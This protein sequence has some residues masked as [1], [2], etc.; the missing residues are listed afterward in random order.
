MKKLDKPMMSVKEIMKDISETVLDTEKKNN[1]IDAIDHIEEC[2]IEYD[3][4]AINHNLH[5]IQPTQNTDTTLDAT[6]MQKLYTEKFSRGKLKGKYYDK[7]MSLSK[8][9][10]CPICGVGQ[11]SNLDHYL[12]KTL[13]PVYAITPVNLTPMCRDCNFKKRD[14]PI[15]SYV[16]SPFHPYYDDIDDMVWLVAKIVKQPEGNIVV[17]YLVNPDINQVNST[18]YNKLKE[19]CKLYELFKLYSIQASTEIAES[20]HAWQKIEINEGAEKL[21]YFFTEC[22]ISREEFQKNTWHTA[23]LRALINDVT[24]IL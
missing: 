12:A 24:V 1:I 13:Y 23:L 18:L 7:L 4:L 19:H 11:I 20:I 5:S 10:K 8:N 16:N 21:K 15:V 6:T 22:L 2:A 14:K 17:E 3:D 9:G